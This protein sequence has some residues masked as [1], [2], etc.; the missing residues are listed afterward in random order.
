MSLRDEK[1]NDSRML[2]SDAGGGFLFIPLYV[3]V[4][5]K[6]LDCSKRRRG[7]HWR[8]SQVLEDIIDIDTYH[9]M[10]IESQ[11]YVILM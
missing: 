1:D 5:N 3:L 4:F 10:I 8:S 11:M 9:I 7:E 2:R 6:K